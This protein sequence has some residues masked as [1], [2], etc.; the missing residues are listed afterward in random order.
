MDVVQF[1]LNRH[2]LG[3]ATMRRM[4][5]YTLFLGVMF[6]VVA[7]THYLLMTYGICT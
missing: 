4:T 2:S 5:K 6:Y 7:G 1:P 3:L